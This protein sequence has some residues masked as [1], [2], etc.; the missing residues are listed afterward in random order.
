MFLQLRAMR[1]AAIRRCAA[2]YSSGA[3][4]SSGSVVVA[5]NIARAERVLEQVRQRFA[6]GCGC[7][8]RLSGPDCVSSNSLLRSTPRTRFD[9]RLTRVRP[10]PHLWEATDDK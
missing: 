7:G 6:S 5:T 4:G 9:K 10:P 8:P 1:E 2:F 3:Q